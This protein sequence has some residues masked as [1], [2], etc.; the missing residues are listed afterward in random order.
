MIYQ[1][2]FSRVVFLS[3]F[4]KRQIAFKESIGNLLSGRYI[5]QDGML[6][7][8]VLLGNEMKISRVNVVGVV[9]SV[10]DES[11]YKSV[12]MDDGSGKLSV[13]SFEQNV[14]LDSL[15]I[16]DC[17]LIIGRPREFG[18]EIYILPEI[19]KK[20]ENP[21]WLELR[22]LELSNAVSPKISSAPE[23]KQVSKGAVPQAVVEEDFVESASSGI[24]NKICGI[25]KDIDSGQGADFEEVIKQADDSGA[26]KIIL[27]L[28]KNGDVFEV[29][30]G[31][32]KV[33]E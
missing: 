11:G 7:N 6:P 27:S 26:E 24:N 33:L 17:V 23:A 29:S 5:K 20:I 2:V 31:K 16:G 9:V 3:E 15:N 14:S 32:L 13:R 30:P 1:T 18:N 10:G 22:K 12:F 25:I 4:Q 28:M 8:Y 21:K 19:V